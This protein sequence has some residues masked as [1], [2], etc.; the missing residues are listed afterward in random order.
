MS[1]QRNDVAN[2][3]ESSGQE[4]CAWTYLPQIFFR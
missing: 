4:D 3:K 2:L 1:R